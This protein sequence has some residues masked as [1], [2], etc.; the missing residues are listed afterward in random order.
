MTK[1]LAS[2]MS[3]RESL[4]KLR[5]TSAIGSSA[6]LC[7]LVTVGVQIA[8]PLVSRETQRVLTIVSVATF[9]LASVFHAWDTRGLN[10]AGAVIVVC[11]GGGLVAEAVGWRTG[12]PFGNYRYGDSLG[13]QIAGVPIVVPLA[14][15]MMGWLALLCGR[16]V[17]DCLQ[18]GRPN[19]MRNWTIVAVIGALVLVTWDLFLDPQMV[20]AGHWYW[21]KTRGP[22]LHGIP[23]V[24]SLGWFIVGALMVWLLHRVVP[25]AM[26]KGSSD[27]LA[28]LLLGW[29][30]F[31]EWFGHLVFFG[32]PSVGI[33]GGV[34]MSL[35][36]LV[37]L[38]PDLLGRLRWPRP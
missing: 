5:P 13:V 27:A 32:S 29:T 24:N 20:D 14:W 10:A 35:A 31:S 2:V 3:V 23:L 21:R 8:Y 18:I 25:K 12:L 4:A 1:S 38:K 16:R 6:M 15:A 11:V 30:W 34:A 36:L 17:A 7:A 33:V 26:R 19:P 22:S 28:W 37:V 9:F